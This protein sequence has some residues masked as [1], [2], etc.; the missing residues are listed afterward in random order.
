MVGF[1]PEP[2]PK[3]GTALLKMHLKG[4]R[5]A[6]KA[7]YKAHADKALYQKMRKN[8]SVATVFNSQTDILNMQLILAR[9]QRGAYL[10]DASKLKS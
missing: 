3:S 6:Y 2:E 5:V 4:R 10:N 8:V 7:P 9:C 1:R